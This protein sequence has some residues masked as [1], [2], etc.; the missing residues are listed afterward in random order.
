VV[1]LTG[2]RRGWLFAHLGHI[3]TTANSRP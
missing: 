2:Q 3:N 1:E